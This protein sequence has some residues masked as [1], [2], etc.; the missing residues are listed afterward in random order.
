MKYNVIINMRTSIFIS[1][2]SVLGKPTDLKIIIT[3]APYGLISS[4]LL[5]G[6][7]GVGGEWRADCRCH[8]GFDPHLPIIYASGF[9][10][11]LA[12]F[13]PLDKT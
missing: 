7:L 6:P 8:R 2:V 5:R 3:F 1:T 4:C 11:P 13:I 10:P 12:D 9:D